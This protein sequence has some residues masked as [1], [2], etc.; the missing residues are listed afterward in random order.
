MRT[1]TLFDT[2]DRLQTTLCNVRE[3]LARADEMMVQLRHRLA[4]RKGG[5]P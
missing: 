1:A 5:S 3:T 2:V 4:S